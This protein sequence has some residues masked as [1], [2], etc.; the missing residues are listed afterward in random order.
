MA[1]MGTRGTASFVDAT[2]S[3]LIAD[4][5]KALARD[6]ADQA[7]F[8]R[9]ADRA[10]RRIDAIGDRRFLYGAA[11]PYGLQTLVLGDDAFRVLHEMGQQVE[12]LR[13]DHDRLGAALQLAA[14]D[15]ED[16]IVEPQPHAISTTCQGTEAALCVS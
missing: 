10:A 2:P 5:A 12:D 6:R 7:L 4:E 14:R 15:V 1:A 9:V 13:P 16:K 11:V 3:S 8:A